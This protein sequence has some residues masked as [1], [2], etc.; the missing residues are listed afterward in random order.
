VFELSPEVDHGTLGRS[1]AATWRV[2]DPG[3]SR[4]HAALLRKPRRGILLVDLA[5]PEGTYVNGEKVEGELLLMDGDR[6]RLG[7]RLELEYLEGPPP[8]ESEERIWLR[9][10]GWALAGLGGTMVLLLLRLL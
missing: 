5:A 2:A 3:I 7:K 10:M 4:L 8:P 1:L 9:R 6:I